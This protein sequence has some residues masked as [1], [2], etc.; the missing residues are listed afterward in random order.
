MTY[1]REQQILAW[2][3]HEIGGAEFV[4]DVAS[5]PE[6]NEDSVYLIVGRTVD[7]VFKRYIERLDTRVI[8]DAKEMKFMDSCL[9]YDGRHAEALGDTMTMSEYSGGGWLYTSTITVTCS[10][11]TFVS[12][13]AG[14]GKE[15]H[16]TG[17][18]GTIV[19][20]SI[21]TYVS[22]TVIRGKPSMTVPVAMRSTAIA[23]W[24]IAITTAKNLWHLEGQDVSILGDGMV[25]GSPNND[26][27]PVY[28]VA[29]GQVTL[30][31][32]Y[33]VIQVGLPYIS[34]IET[35]NIDT[36][37]VQTIADR[38][39]FVSKVSIHTEKTR[40]VF[41]G[42]EPPSDDATDPLEG[43]TEIKVR[44]NE[45][46]LDPVELKSEV[47]D[48]NIQPEWNSNGRIFIRQVDPLPMGVL[49]IMPAGLFPFQGR[50]Q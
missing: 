8:S 12:T 42:A 37:S 32:A 23:D 14:V 36:D 19:R 29:N 3:R 4:Y 2:H 35:L 38:N 34:D 41:I 18:D 21:D 17:D 28:T 10:L 40:G 15:V 39:K 5:V 46:Y 16:I 26:S 45:G 47:L 20:V 11:S 43:L 24:A 44:D 33:S 22:G 31:R 30:D 27:Y 13:D 50:G 7:G 48:V 25:V 49:S 6:G 1:V 9:T